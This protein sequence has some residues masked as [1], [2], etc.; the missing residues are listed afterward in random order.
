MLIRFPRS[1][2]P[3]VCRPY[4]HTK[5]KGRHRQIQKWPFIMN[6]L[7]V[8]CE[9]VAAIQPRLSN[10][11]PHQAP[12]RKWVLSLSWV[13]THSCDRLQPE[14]VW[15]VRNAP[16]RQL[17]AQQREYFNHRCAARS[18]IECFSDVAPRLPFLIDRLADTRFS[19]LSASQSPARSSFLD[20]FLTG[21]SRRNEAVIIRPRIRLL[22]TTTPECFR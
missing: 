12:R 2:F 5:F 14:P 7:R 16:H 8:I 4:V 6:S 17:R 11:D 13:E 21:A 9:R 15:P 20:T 3:I 18:L 1:S 10:P 22:T 19:R